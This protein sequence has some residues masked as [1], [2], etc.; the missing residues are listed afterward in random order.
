MPISK[1]DSK[2]IQQFAKE[3][4]QTKRIVEDHFPQL[5]YAEVAAVVRDWGEKSA[6]GR[7]RMITARLND[8]AA[9]DDETART[10]MV[11]EVQNLVKELYKNH[12][13]S[14]DKLATIREALEG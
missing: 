5:S 2:K 14:H 9:M 10:K 4:K 1:A 12:K 6:L 3:G 8:I 13:S 7:M 11:K